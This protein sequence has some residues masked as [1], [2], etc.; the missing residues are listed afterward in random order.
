VCHYGEGPTQW[1]AT[2]DA[3]GEWIGDV[4]VDEL[5]IEQM[6]TRRGRRD[7]HAALIQLS[8][9]SGATY[10][11]VRADEMSAIEPST[12]TRNRPKKTNHR[13]VRKRLDDTETEALEDGLSR[14]P[15][16]NEKEV[17]DA[18]G[19]GLHVLTRL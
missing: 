9:V 7:A 8:Q 6:V 13:R 18:V 10:S 16:S 11:V 15:A 19:I 14:A 3:I 2:A 4:D 17:L 12:W 1:V 5:A